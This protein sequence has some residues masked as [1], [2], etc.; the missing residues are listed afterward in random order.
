MAGSILSWY[1]E[2]STVDGLNEITEMN[3]QMSMAKMSNEN[4]RTS[5]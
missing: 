4:L 5:T 1:T 3:L 2:E